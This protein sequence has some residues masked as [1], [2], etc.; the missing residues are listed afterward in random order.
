MWADYKG[1]ELLRDDGSYDEV[2]PECEDDLICNYGDFMASLTNG[3]VRSPWHR[4]VLP[5]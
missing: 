2:H 1:L 5:P 4:V 3:K